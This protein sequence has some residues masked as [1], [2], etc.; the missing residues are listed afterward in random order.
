MRFS[1][2]ASLDCL[3]DSIDAA[4]KSLSQA[5]GGKKTLTKTDTITGF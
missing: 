1:Y 4:N 3:T 2:L 5:T